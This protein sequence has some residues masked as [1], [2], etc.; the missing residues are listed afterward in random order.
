V[1]LTVRTVQRWRE[2][3]G[4]DDRRRGPST[5]PHNKLS[6]D[7]EQRVLDIANSKEFHDVSPRQIVPTLADRNLYYASESAFYRLLRKHGL[8]HHRARSRPPTTRPRALTAT[9][10]DQV[11]SWDITYL[12]SR[13]RGV[14]FYLYLVVDIWSR[15]VVGWAIHDCESGDLAAALVERICAANPRSGNLLWLHSD[16]GAAMKSAPLLARLT[17]LGIEPSFSR[18]RVSNDNPYSEA[19]F[20]TLKY[21]PTFP[22]RPFTDIAAAIDWVER[23]VDWYNT[24]HLHSAINFV[25]PDDR[26][27][28]RHLKILSARRRVYAAARCLHPERW[29]GKT[30][31]WDPI[32]VVC[33]NPE[34]DNA[35]SKSKAKHA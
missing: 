17:T 7:E 12:R 21:R 16:N 14:Y 13:V 5:T 23:F 10:P 4:G 29:T 18:P 22:A 32:R 3:G 26:H 1:G 19:L 34:Y 6:A 8:L 15:R 28:G 25:T 27:F 31:N 35:S 33:L 20:R 30:R 24:K 11:Y 2:Q 9:G